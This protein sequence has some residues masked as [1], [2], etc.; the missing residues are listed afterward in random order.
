M[1]HDILI[2]VLKCINELRQASKETLVYQ[3]KCQTSILRI[4]S[5]GNFSQLFQTVI[6]F[7]HHRMQHM[8]TL[9]L[10][11]YWGNLN[12]VQCINCLLFKSQLIQAMGQNT[13]HMVYGVVGTFTIMYGV[14]HVY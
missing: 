4:S 7:Y 14:L 10:A 1:F 5:H 6:P 2:C 3:R 12:I 8:R 13:C 11:S 9:I